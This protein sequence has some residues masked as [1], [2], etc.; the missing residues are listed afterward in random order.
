[1][2]RPRRLGYSIY[3]FFLTLSSMITMMLLM[4]M[5]GW[6]NISVGVGYTIGYAIS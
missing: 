2:V 6:V 1:M 5:N 4:T 3:T